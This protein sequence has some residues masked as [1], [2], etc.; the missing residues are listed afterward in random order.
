[1]SVLVVNPYTPHPMGELAALEPP[2]WAARYGYPVHDCQEK[3]LDLDNCPEEVWLVAMGNNPSVSSTPKMPEVIRL[4]RELKRRGK[5][6]R[7]GGLHP[8]A[9]P[10]LTMQ[11]CGCDSILPMPTGEVDWSK[12]PMQV[13]CAH[14]WHAQDRSH[15]AA[16]YTAYGCPFSCSW[17][18]IKTLYRT[19]H[20]RPVMAVVDECRNL[21][22]QYG[23]RN[24]KLCDELFTVHSYRAIDLCERITDL[25]LNIWAYARVGT[26]I[27]QA[28]LRAMK[29]AGINWLAYG[30]ESFDPKVRGDKQYENE[31]WTIK[32]T[33]DAGIKIIANFIFGL[34][35][36]TEKTMHETLERAI[37]YRFDWV[38][39]YTY[40][41]YPGSPDWRDNY[42]HDWARYDQYNPDRLGDPVAIKFRKQ[43]FEEYF[44][45]VK[46]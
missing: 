38:N 46:G 4:S 32:A 15:Y 28:I 24:L 26:I 37:S 25:K 44:R 6:V 17:C 34:P 36:D 3:P 16:I 31:D 41:P 7:I 10:E 35:G 22:A 30:F 18:N 45:R 27:N 21:V 12:L 29:Q 43:A 8:W 14:N 42:S 13:Y 20:P 2:I 1:M 40:I 5:I 11:E 39:F 33:Q 19:W 9:L 23:V